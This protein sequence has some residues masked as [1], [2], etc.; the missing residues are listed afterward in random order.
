MKYTYIPETIVEFMGGKSGVV[1]SHWLGYMAEHAYCGG[2]TA[3]SWCKHVSNLP[4]KF[5]FHALSFLFG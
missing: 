3:V 1:A 5:L 2:D 4:L